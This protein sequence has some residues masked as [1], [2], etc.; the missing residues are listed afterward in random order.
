MHTTIQQ[1]QLQSH[2]QSRLPDTYHGC[3]LRVTTPIWAPYVMGDNE[4]VTEGFEVFMLQT[5]TERL[6]LN[7]SFNV[8]DQT[9]VFRQFTRDDPHGFYSDLIKR[10]GIIS[11]RVQ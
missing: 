6:D 11:K 2:F 9:E 7:L 3:P 5:F 10:Y 1:K 4:S 8:I